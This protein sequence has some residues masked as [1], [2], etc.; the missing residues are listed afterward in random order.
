MSR[1]E[2]I[3]AHFNSDKVVRIVAKI[4][5]ARALAKEGVNTVDGRVCGS[6]V[7]GVGWLGLS[8]GLYA[9][10]RSRQS[11]WSATVP[12]FARSQ[13]PTLLGIVAPYCVLLRTSFLQLRNQVLLYACGI[14]F[15]DIVL[16]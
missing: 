16:S 7:G 3:E 1:I 13:I 12:T 4:K 15:E 6:P 14:R 8:I 11:G 10:Y 5:R 2:N 9:G